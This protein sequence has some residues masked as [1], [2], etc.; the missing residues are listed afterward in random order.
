MKKLMALGAVALIALTVGVSAKAAPKTQ[1]A[2]ERRI[3]WDTQHIRQLNHRRDVL[4]RYIR[5]IRAELQAP[6]PTSTT[7]STTSTASSTSSTSTSS[8]SLTATSSGWADE[9][10]AVG[11]P[12]SAIPQMLYYI[13]R[14]SGG[15]PSA[16]N[17]SSNACGLTQIYP[18]VAG[19]L[20][21]MTNLRLAFQKYQA[22]G[23]APWGG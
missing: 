14:E 11:F 9:L 2:L 6:A 16:L 17:P 18:Y 23:F 3:A 13:N 21:P 7:T 1:A 5:H 4:H 15:D 10:R 12:E 22:S 19:C 8:G 20:D